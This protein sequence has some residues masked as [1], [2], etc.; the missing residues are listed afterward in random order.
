MIKVGSLFLGIQS[1]LGDVDPK[2]RHY[3]DTEI[4]EAINS[5][6]AHVSEELLCFSR[7]WLI[8]CIDG[9]NR[10]KLPS[11]VL[12]PI[13]ANYNK[14]HIENVVSMEALAKPSSC[15]CGVTVA[16]DLQTLHLFNVPLVKKSDVIELYYNYTESIND[17][18]DTIDL[19]STAK[20]SLIYYALGLLFENNVSS[21]GIEKSN[22][23]K[24]L[25][26]LELAKV[27]SRVRKNQQSKHIISYFNGV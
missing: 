27:R 10:Y 5:A 3:N 19:P 24:Q 2:K 14:K 22:R 8:P 25:Y 17:K 4:I 20:E 13:S 16:Y 6:L 15:A 26:E 23:F 21:R 11:D 12:R 1:R 9:V 18:T 7:T